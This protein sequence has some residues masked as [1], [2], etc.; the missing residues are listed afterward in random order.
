MSEATA[1]CASN[2][3]KRRGAKGGVQDKDEGREENAYVEVDAIAKDC[4][5]VARWDVEC[6]R[7]VDGREKKEKDFETPKI[8]RRE[9]VPEKMG[10]KWGKRENW[11]ELP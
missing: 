11:Q 2:A 4:C 6:C 5:R 3:A 1:F 7:F 8:F 10:G 9:G